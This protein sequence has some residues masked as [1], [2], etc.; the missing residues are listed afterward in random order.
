MIT[1]S[2]TEDSTALKQNECIPDE[3]DKIKIYSCENPD[4]LVQDCP[5]GT[6][7]KDRSCKKPVA[8]IEGIGAIYDIAASYDKATYDSRIDSLYQLGTTASGV[9]RTIG[10][11]TTVTIAKSL[12]V[13]PLAS[14]L[15]VAVL[16][17]VLVRFFSQM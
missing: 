12:A 5:K 10:A 11:T 7:C 9:G 3:P 6:L 1:G 16:V 13:K 14:P 2:V 4:G 8:Y 17:V 15:A